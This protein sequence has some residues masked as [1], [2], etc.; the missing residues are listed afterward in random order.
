MTIKNITDDKNSHVIT[1]ILRLFRNN[2]F[3][4]TGSI[5]EQPAFKQPVININTSIIHYGYLSTDKDLME[6]KFRRNLEL[7]KNELKKDPENIYFLFQLSQS[8]GCIMIRN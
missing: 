1:N 5:H 7:I 2:N 3:F 6:Y 8:Y 4:Y